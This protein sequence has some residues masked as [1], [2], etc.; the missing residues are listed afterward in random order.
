V[1]IGAGKEAWFYNRATRSAQ[2]LVVEYFGKIN[3]LD[4]IAACFEKSALLNR[5]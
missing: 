2:C 4:F 1:G 5:K 3:P